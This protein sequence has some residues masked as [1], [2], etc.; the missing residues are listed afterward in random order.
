MQASVNGTLDPIDTL[1]FGTE[2][3]LI[4]RDS[5]QN[6][7]SLAVDLIDDRVVV[8]VDM[9]GGD[10]ERL[11]MI[12]TGSN[13]G[14][15]KIDLSNNQLPITFLSDGELPL[16]D[17]G[18]L[19]LR[20]QDIPADIYAEY[21][22]PVDATGNESVTS[23]QIAKMTLATGS[24]HMPDTTSP[25][26]TFLFTLND[27]DLNN[28][29]LSKESY[30]LD[31]RA[32][33]FNLTRT[34]ESLGMLAYMKMELN[35][36][37]L[38]FG[39]DHLSYTLTETDINTGSFKS[40]LNM[41]DIAANGNNG[42]PL[43]LSGG[44]QFKVIYF[45]GMGPS[46][47]QKTDIMTISGGGGT[48]NTCQGLTATIVGTPGNDYINGTAGVDVIVGLGGDDII[49][50]LRGND[51]I[52]G[53]DGKDKQ[54]GGPGNDTLSGDA[55]ND[56]LSG[57]GGKDKLIGGIGNDTLKGGGGDDNL[58]G[59]DGDDKL[60]GQAGTDTLDGGAGSNVLVQD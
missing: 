24:V 34:S 5:D 58:S 54:Y 49:Y 37:P 11:D 59:G 4:V 20:E 56:T 10:V 31:I 51:V 46:W 17:D 9:P 35:G 40:T 28:N 16:I 3:K 21:W 55:G 32:D 47:V 57:G 23:V 50:G 7:D 14:A 22:D 2:M 29:A 52:C 36:T 33:I 42:N 41:A 26:G 25:T 6:L 1:K 19:E 60:Y 43:S 38:H 45:D 13:T 27:S 8:A 44:D 30:V 12:E 53:G 18:V 39:S 15:F 48:S